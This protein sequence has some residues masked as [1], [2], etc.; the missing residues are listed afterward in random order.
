MRDVGSNSSVLDANMCPKYQSICKA[1]EPTQTPFYDA[2][3]YSLLH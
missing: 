2:A 3:S 1:G